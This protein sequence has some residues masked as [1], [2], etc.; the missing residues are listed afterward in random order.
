MKLTSTGRQALQTIKDRREKDLIVVLDELRAKGK[1][2]E[3]GRFFRVADAAWAGM[4]GMIQE[5]KRKKPV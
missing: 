2:E 1:T 4:K 3:Q 5:N